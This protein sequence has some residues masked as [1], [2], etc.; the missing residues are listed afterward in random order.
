MANRLIANGSVGSSNELSD[1]VNS[2]LGL[3]L[4]YAFD[5]H[6]GEGSGYLLAV[7][8]EA[9]GIFLVSQ[10]ST[11][12]HSCIEQLLRVDGLDPLA[13]SALFQFGNLSLLL[14]LASQKSTLLS[15]FS[16]ELLSYSLELF[17]R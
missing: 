10:S 1:R 7:R 9:F 6:L 16:H 2:L 3:G 8:L 5:N 13:P 12:S 15:N 14:Q 17:L 4:N 11:D